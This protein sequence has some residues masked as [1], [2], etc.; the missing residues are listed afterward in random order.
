MQVRK[1]IA[2]WLIVMGMVGASIAYGDSI[3]QRYEN[4]AQNYHRLFR[5]TEYRKREDNWLKVIRTFQ[6]IFKNHPK[7][8]KAAPSLYNIG[9]LYRGLFRWNA[10]SIY[11]DRSNIA[12]RTLVQK[13]PNSRLSDD[14]QFLLAENYEIL[15]KDT[16][17][18]YF[19]YQK[20]ITLFPNHPMA[21]KAAQKLAKLDPVLNSAPSAPPPENAL[22]PLD[23][24]EA[25][26]GG[27]RQEEL[28]NTHQL[29]LVSKVNNWSTA[30]WS[31][32][33]V[34]VSAGT[35][36]KYQVFPADGKKRKGHRMVLDILHA[37]L[38]THFNKTIATRG[39]LLKQAGIAQFD[40]RTVR[41]VLD[42]TS[43][44]KVKVFDFSLPNQYKIVVD[45][46]GHSATGDRIAT[47]SAAPPSVA[48][49][50]NSK[51]TIPLVESLGLK[52]QRIILDPGHGGK[53]PGAIAFGVAEKEI[54]LKIATRL[55]H[56]I[57]REQP[58]M[59]V[60]L[61]RTRDVY[62]E[63]EARTAF[64]NK[65][66]GDL[67]ISIHVNASEEEQAVGMET[68]TLNLTT[69][70]QALAL[71]ATE[72]QSTMK[73]I[74]ELQNILNE[75]M[76]DS[77]IHESGL[78]AKYIQE[79]AVD[80]IRATKMIHLKDLGVKQAPFIVLLGAQMPSVLIEVGFL[81]NKKEHTLLTSDQYHIALAQGIF[82]GIHTYMN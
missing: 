81:T 14:A 16:N 26:Y 72:N 55:K 53:D 48:A 35:R 73:N 64:A 33:V 63:L 1:R 58:N 66:K 28:D 65:N 62:M 2:G 57:H 13:Y 49:Q 78:L 31:R 56:I 46:L 51:K 23:L 75:L 40:T 67:F 21:P 70:H 10:K 50:E 41:I 60:L 80:V 5:P 82:K 15:K 79:S 27:I 30:D 38:P 47:N 19:E 12:F 45:I 71:A 36:Y 43:L 37:R 77:K 9:N 25:K 22:P 68:Y 39:G 74:G 6:S 11:L 4:A 29:L 54:A 20:L 69:D 8:R 7:H 18:A 42:L 61:T 52:V 59:E 3:D 24:K 32:M 44:K 76:T 34:N 17:L